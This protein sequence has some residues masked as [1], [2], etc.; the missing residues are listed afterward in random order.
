MHYNI[1]KM[2]KG[3]INVEF[4]LD[5]NEW[6]NY[7]EQAYQKEKGKYKK[8]GFR[9]G[10]VPRKVLENSYGDSL[11]YESA[12]DLAFPKIYTQMLNSEKSI[13]PVDYPEIDIKKV[14]T[15]GLQFTTLITLLP[16]VSLGEY[17]G[18]EIN[19][20]KIEVAD[21]EVNE[22]INRI[23]ERNARY[24]DVTNRAA[25]MGD[26]V[27][28]NY[29][30]SVDNVPFDGGSAKNYELELG[31]N[32]FIPGFEDG[33]VGM[34]IGE[35]KPINVTFP[36]NYH[37]ASLAN[38]PA[39]FVVDLLSIRQ[40]IL[41]VIN[42]EFAKDVSDNNSLTELKSQIKDKILNQKVQNQEMEIENELIKKIVNSS[43][44]EVPDCMVERQID[45]FIDEFSSRLS[46]QGLKFS[47]YLKYIGKSESDYRE[48][49]R[50]EALSAVKTNL[51]LEQIIKNENISA[52][53]QEISEHF[54]KHQQKNDN[55]SKKSTKLTI[56]E[57]QKNTIKHHIIS[58]KLI[59]FLKNKNK[60][61]IA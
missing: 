46:Y 11:F 30:G 55:A 15:D 7:V 36:S 13:V 53:E 40:K 50:K 8:E 33:V 23:A 10:K 61:V 32:T 44:V 28:I 31:S 34:K 14:G 54:Y 52:S 24:E 47:D 6:E 43:K 3:K 42:D 39:V 20:K 59:E 21:S 35:S 57:E 18:I 16:E 51:V 29:A 45:Y 12:F 25:K 17:T 60:I 26:L 27:E 48:L 41:P 1:G 49:Q 9:Q 2:S 22:E 56:S 58:Q 4:V 38:K 37:E 19:K 5:S